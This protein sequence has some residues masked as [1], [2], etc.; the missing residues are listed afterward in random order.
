MS[1]LDEANAE[2]MLIVAIETLYDVKLYDWNVLNP[3]NFQMIIMCSYGLN[4]YPESVTLYSWLIKLYGKLGLVKC[5][6]T[7][8]EVFPTAP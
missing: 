3:I 4:F 6:N 7:L 5:V 8:S 1:E 2:D